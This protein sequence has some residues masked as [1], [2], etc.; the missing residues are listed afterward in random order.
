MNPELGKVKSFSPDILI[1]CIN[2]RYGNMNWQDAFMLAHRLEVKL[3]IPMHYDLFAI[4]TEDP[5][6]FVN[7]FDRSSIKGK[8]LERC[9]AY[10]IASLL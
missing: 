3:A 8:I 4:N 2:G 1:S 7:A 6:L 5:S 9:K 10:D